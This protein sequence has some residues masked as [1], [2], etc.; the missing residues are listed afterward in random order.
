MPS[1]ASVSFP[2]TIVRAE[3]VDHGLM[4][5]GDGEGLVDVA[6]VG[7][8]DGAGVVR[9]SASYPTGAALRDATSASDALVVT[10]NNRLR[11]RR[12]TSV[13]ENVDG[14]P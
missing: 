14:A 13:N 5:S 6:G 8:L 11:A 9:Y 4:V 2:T 3:S 10:D 7:L 12:W 1:G